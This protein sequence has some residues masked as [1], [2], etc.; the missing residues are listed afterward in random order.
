MFDILDYQ[1]EDDRDPFKEW[2]AG[3]ADRQARARVAVRVQRMAAGNFGDH[4]PLSEGVWELKID[5]G[6]GYRVYYARAGRR[7]LLL[8]VGGDK[9]RQQA[10]IATAVRYWQDWQR[11][12]AQ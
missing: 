1:A 11:R 3:L 12:N 10:D 6:P 5:H 7:V 4:K 8:L 9:R 2:L